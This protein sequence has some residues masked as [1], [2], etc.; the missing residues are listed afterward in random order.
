[1]RFL[2]VD[3]DPAVVLGPNAAQSVPVFGLR[4]VLSR[5]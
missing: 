1:M 3:F 5:G 4:M 2:E